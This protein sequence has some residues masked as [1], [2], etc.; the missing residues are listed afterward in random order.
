MDKICTAVERIIAG[1]T[2]PAT[3]ARAAERFVPVA[4]RTSV[5]PVS[6]RKTLSAAPPDVDDGG[7]KHGE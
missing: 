3:V 4:W 2:V 5:F 1:A 7:E 6:D